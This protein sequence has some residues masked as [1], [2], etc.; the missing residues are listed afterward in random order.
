[1]TKTVVSLSGSIVRATCMVV[2]SLLSLKPWCLVIKVTIMHIP[3]EGPVACGIC[4]AFAPTQVSGLCLQGNE[5]WSA[6]NQF[7]QYDANKLPR[8]QRQ[9]QCNASNCSPIPQCPAEQCIS[10]PCG[11]PEQ[12]IDLQTDMA[13]CG[14]CGLACPDPS[15]LP[16]VTSV[17]C[18]DGTCTI[19]GCAAG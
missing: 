14:A 15:I 13:N 2:H 12:K 10:S 1:V 6:G 17:G 4:N 18:L 5:Y 8:N 11:T 3:L 9:P 16:Q 7:L 19:T